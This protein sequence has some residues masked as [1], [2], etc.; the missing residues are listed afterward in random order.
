[1]EQLCPI[2]GGNLNATYGYVINPP[3][4]CEN[5]TL[6]RQKSNNVVPSL[7]YLC[8]QILKQSIYSVEQNVFAIETLEMSKELKKKDAH[9]T[10][11]YNEPA[12]KTPD[13]D[14]DISD[15]NSNDDVADPD[16]DVMDRKQILNLDKLTSE[17]AYDLIDSIT[18]DQAFDSDLGGDSDAE[19]DLPQF[20]ITFFKH[21]V[22]KTF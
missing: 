16:Y 9:V 15:F 21:T 1:M 5:K 11:E 17:E 12:H 4:T 10:G 13:R 20:F 8:S 22:A 2:K 14:V 7:S 6:N 18:D 3:G 19:D